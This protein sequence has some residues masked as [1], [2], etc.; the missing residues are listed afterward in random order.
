M[1]LNQKG[2]YDDSNHPL[3]IL[4]SVSKNNEDPNICLTNAIKIINGLLIPID[5]KDDEIKKNQLAELRKINK[6]KRSNLDNQNFHINKSNEN[7][8]YP[9]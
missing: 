4:I 6:Q 5:E 1:N 3:H 2:S 7:R 8:F 9:Y